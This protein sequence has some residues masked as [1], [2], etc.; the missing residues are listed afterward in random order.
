MSVAPSCQDP[1]LVPP[2]RIIRVTLILVDV[3]HALTAQVIVGERLTEDEDAS[4]FHQD[5]LQGCSGIR[6]GTDLPRARYEQVQEIL[7]PGR[8]TPLEQHPCV[9]DEGGWPRR[10]VH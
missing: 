8:R 6:I 2:L 7:E 1:V 3:V 10:Q 5:R 9:V 4:A